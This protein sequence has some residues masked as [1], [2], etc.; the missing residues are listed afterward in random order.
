M[1]DSLWN[2]KDVSRLSPELLERR[3]PSSL[4]NVKPLELMGPSVSM[5]SGTKQCVLARAWYFCS[6][7][8]AAPSAAPPAKDGVVARYD[9]ARVSVT[10]TSQVKHRPPCHGISVSPSGR[11]PSD[12]IRPSGSLIEGTPARIRARQTKS[13]RL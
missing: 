2:R 5:A 9:C 6:F 1:T 12:L 10:V 13:L 7:L 4:K 11:L 3:R 8:W